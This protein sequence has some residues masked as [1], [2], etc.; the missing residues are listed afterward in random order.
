MKALLFDMD[1]VLV[2]VSGSYRKAVQETA[3]FFTGKSINEGIIQEYKNRGG[4]NNDWDLTEHILREHRHPAE[5]EKIIRVFQE[6]YYGRNNSGLVRNEIWL[7][8]KDILKKISRFYPCAIITGRPFPDAG[9]A[10]KRF[11]T[12]SYFRAVIT[13]DHVP[14]DKQKPHPLGILMALEELGCRQGMY[15][16]DNVDDMIAAKSAGMEAVGVVPP[17]AGREEHRKKLLS[18]GAVKVL[19]SI[20][21]IQEVL[22]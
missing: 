15:F 4:F 12:E 3:A 22:P 11:K 13:M 5:K 19:D 20:N 16:G 10:L 21:R 6:K 17:G 2:D 14:E 8:D 1:G 18:H 7:M 9:F